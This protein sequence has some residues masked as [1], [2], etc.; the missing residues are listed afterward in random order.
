MFVNVIKQISPSTVVYWQLIIMSL[1]DS[2][3][4]LYICPTDTAEGLDE[5]HKKKM[6]RLVGENKRVID[7]GCATGYFSTTYKERMQVT[8]LRLTQ[9]QPR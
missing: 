7:F 5:N 1:S 2:W 8:A 4:R 9:T 6:L 3:K